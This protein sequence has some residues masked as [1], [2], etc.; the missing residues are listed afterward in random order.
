[1]TKKEQEPGK[2]TN[3]S[4]HKSNNLKYD[5]EITKQDKDVLN[6]QSQDED[7]GEYFEERQEPIDYEGEDLDVPEFDDKQFNP[8]ASKADESEK[9]ELPKQSANSDADLKSE[10]ETVYKGSDAEKYKDPSK[11]SRT[12]NRKNPSENKDHD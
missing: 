4:E 9:E 8:T 1:M 2:D 10:T 3:Q 5:P 11:E 7:K 12:E 6:N